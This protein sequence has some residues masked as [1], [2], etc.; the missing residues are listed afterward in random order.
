MAY[1][2]FYSNG[3]SYEDYEKY[4]DCICLTEKKAKERKNKV[5]KEI[6]VNPSKY[7]IYKDEVNYVDVWYEE[8][9]L[10]D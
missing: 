2:V 6:K 9:E 10:I 7:G 3:M 5:D 1:V 4:I 8:A